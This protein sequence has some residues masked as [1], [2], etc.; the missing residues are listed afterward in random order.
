MNMLKGAALFV[1]G[2]IIGATGTMVFLKDKYAKELDE[3]LELLRS[4][5]QDKKDDE[6]KAV[7]YN[8]ILVDNKYIPYETMNDKEVRKHVNEIVDNVIATDI[9]PEDYPSEP[10]EIDEIEYSE[11]GLYFEKVEV[12]YYLGDGA[13]V[14][15]AE[16]MVNIEDNIGYNNVA[17]FIS[18]D[19]RDVMYIRNAEKGID[20]LVNKV[21]GNYSDIIGLGGDDDE[22]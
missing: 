16:E 1:L 11:R 6:I 7:E 14:D 13:L 17:K 19:S 8:D 20:Y 21:S 5:Y 2:G 22:D 9:P 4:A 15:E 3:E 10:I 18:D 12:D